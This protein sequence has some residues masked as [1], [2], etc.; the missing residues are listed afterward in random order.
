MIERKSYEVAH[1]PYKLDEDPTKVRRAM[2]LQ[3][4]LLMSELAIPEEYKKQTYYTLISHFIAAE[5]PFLEERRKRWNGDPSANLFY[6]N[7]NHTYQ[8]GFDATAIANTLIRRRDH[9]AEHLSPEGLLAL[10]I[11]G[12]YHDVGYVTANPNSEN[13]ATHTPVHVEAGIKTA[14]EMAELIPFPDFLDNVKIVE[15]IRQGIHNTHFPFSPEKQNERSVMIGELPKDWR[16][17]AMIVRIATQLADLGGQ[18]IRVDQYPKG[19]M[20]LRDELEAACPGLGYKVIGTD[21]DLI[22]NAKM[23][24]KKVVL[25]TVGKTSNA[26]FGNRNIY[27]TS[28][29]YLLFRS[30]TTS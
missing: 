24:T 19:T 8:A 30:N 16:K 11:A 29:N 26:F 1:Y 2:G 3:Y 14:T 17:E 27:Q 13:L 12:I 23:F 21:E 15:F 7:I 10:T 5:R 25:P 22:E 6:H 4:R 20:D 28:W 9:L 18:T